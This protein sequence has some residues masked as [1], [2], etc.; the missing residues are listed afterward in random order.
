ME[1]KSYVIDCNFVLKWFFSDEEDSNTT[2]DFLTSAKEKKLNLYSPYLICIEF[3]NVLTKYYRKGNIPLNK[4]LI[5]NRDF[6]ELYKKGIPK[7]VDLNSFRNEIL[8]LALSK[9][10][11]YY[12]AEYLFLAKMLNAEL[13]TFDKELKK[14]VK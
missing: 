4:C 9:K 13:L 6:Q 11:S 7:L 2:M 8:D 5:F 1:S 3:S 14:K 10:N 12:D